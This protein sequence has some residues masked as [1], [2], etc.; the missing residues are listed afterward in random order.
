[1]RIKVTKAERKSEDVIITTDFIRLDSLLKFKG[2]AMTGGEAKSFIQDGI[3]K[4]DGEVCTARG[5][6]IRKGNT[7]SVFSVDYHIK[8]ED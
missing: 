5:K 1:M 4:V 6:K 8:N 2:I 7:V 3:V